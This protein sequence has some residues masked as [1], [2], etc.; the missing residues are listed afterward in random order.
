M[1]R[2]TT[3]STRRKSRRTKRGTR[4]KS[5][6]K[7]RKTKRRRTRRRI[8]GG[9]NMEDF[10]QRNRGESATDY[11]KA[12]L[13]DKKLENAKDAHKTAVK[14]AD[15]ESQKVAMSK[16]L[17]IEMDLGLKENEQY[18]VDTPKREAAEAAEAAAEVE[19]AAAKAAAE[20]DTQRENRRTAEMSRAAQV[21]AQATAQR[22]I[23][24]LPYAERGYEQYLAREEADEM[25]ETQKELIRLKIKE[26]K[27]DKEA[28]DRDEARRAEGNRIIRKESIW[29]D[30]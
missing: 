10:R 26:R 23:A 14:N 3:R 5:R 13:D 4:R 17:E 18:I 7:S 12:L 25:K 28:R 9:M 20:T 6:R 30:W 29:S 27:L 2:R 15:M 16:I 22:R 24:K 1:T 21:E 8:R 11:I 19:A